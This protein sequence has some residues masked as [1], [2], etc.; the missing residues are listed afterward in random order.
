MSELQEEMVK[1]LR[2][3]ENGLS[4]EELQSLLQDQ[5]SSLK[6][7]PQWVISFELNSLRVKGLTTKIGSLWSLRN[8][9]RS[10]SKSAS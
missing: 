5:R 7:V 4:V 1:I 3:Y 2:E 8:W 9:E 6:N 10:A